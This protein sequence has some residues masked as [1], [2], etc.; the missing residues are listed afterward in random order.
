MEYYFLIKQKNLYRLHCFKAD[1][2]NY[3]MENLFVFNIFV[4]LKDTGN[5]MNWQQY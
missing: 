1:C 3:M 4:A 5:E 2:I